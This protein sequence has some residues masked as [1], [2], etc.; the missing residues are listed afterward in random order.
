MNFF[1]DYLP[2]GTFVFEYDM[3]AT[4]VGEFSNGISQV[5][6]MYA[7]EFTSHSAGKRV[8]VR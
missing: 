7:P 4:Q 1:F 2:K 5:Q 6:S 3:N 8:E